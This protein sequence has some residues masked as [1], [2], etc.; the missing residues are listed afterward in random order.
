MTE[1]MGSDR[2]KGHGASAPVSTWIARFAPLIPSKGHVPHQSRILDLACGGGRHSRFLLDQGFA[3]TALDRDTS[4]VADLAQRAEIITADL[5]DGAPFPLAGR[6]FEGIVVTNYLYRP[7]LPQLI[8]MITPGGLL[9]YETFALGNEK[10]GKPSNPAFLLRPGELLDA[11]RGKL[12]VLA[13]EDLEIQHPRQAAVQRI[14]A[15]R[16]TAP[17][18]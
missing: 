2:Q 5:E 12:R 3:V 6:Q 8:E 10:Y 1:N 13:Y 14:C 16:E 17:L 4:K 18:T 9:L 15:R 11:V 7:L